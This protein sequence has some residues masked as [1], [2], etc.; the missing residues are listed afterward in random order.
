[1]VRRIRKRP[2]MTS[3]H[4]LRWKTPSHSVLSSKDGTVVSGNDA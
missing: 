3:A 2:R 4:V 1:M